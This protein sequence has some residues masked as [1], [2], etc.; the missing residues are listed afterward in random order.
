M[1]K[2]FITGVSSGL[3]LA[4][5]K[6]L[7]E[8]GDSVY[9]V[10]RKEIAPKDYPDDGS[11][12][13]MIWQPCDVTKL[14]D[15]HRII[16]HQ[17]SIEFCPDVVILNSGMHF[18][19]GGD[20][21]Y[22]DY[23]KLFKVNC[24]G[25]LGWVEAFLPGFKNRGS[26]HFVYIS[27]LAASFPFPFRGAYSASKAYASVAFKCLQKQFV[28]SGINFTVIYAGLLDTKMSSGANIPEFF[29]YPVSKGA[30]I[31]LQA[32]ESEA[33]CKYFPLR[34]VLLECFLMLLP[35]SILIKILGERLQQSQKTRA[36]DM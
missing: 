7:L 23:E 32:V 8:R 2:F 11:S 21:I 20:F 3:G 17:R 36:G 27:S 34:A 5:C 12:E 6:Q 30:E 14:E 16:A 25:A 26:G 29:K 22:D 15:I 19:E 33:G 35:S 28:G 31:V 24:A 9:G 4:L 13:K 1:K 10:S 18:N